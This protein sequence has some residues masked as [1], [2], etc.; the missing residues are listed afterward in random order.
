MSCCPSAYLPATATAGLKF[1]ATV[2]LQ[3]YPAPSWGLTLHLRGP[4]QIDVTSTADG[5]KHVLTAP[6]SVTTAWQ[7]G[8]YWYTLRATDGDEVVEIDTGN[9]RILP[10]LVNAPD[11]FDGRSEWEIGLAAIDAVIARRATLDQERY[12]I[13]NRELYH[14]PIGDLLKLRAYYAMKVK[15][16]CARKSGRKQFGRQINVRFTE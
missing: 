11:G 4:K 10:D 7:A 14:T 6:A 15:Q 16:E 9:L 12:R 3:N 8:D 2:E 1:T 5:T 13:N